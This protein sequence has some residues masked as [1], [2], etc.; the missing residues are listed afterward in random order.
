MLI[1]TP[2][3]QSTSP[4]DASRDYRT[5]RPTISV[6]SVSRHGSP[7]EL[8]AMIEHCGRWVRHGVELVL[9]SPGPC[10]LSIKA[11]AARAGVRCIQGPADAT[12]PHLR[13]LGFAAATGDVI[14]IVHDLLAADD[15]WIEHVK[16]MVGR[17]VIQD[18]HTER[19]SAI[20]GTP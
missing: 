4:T 18:R 10:T 15:S 16:T 3:A 8:G 9:V 11:A 5:G 19:D 6:V 12:E 1:I 14:M 2:D 17:T 13:R 20:A 7:S